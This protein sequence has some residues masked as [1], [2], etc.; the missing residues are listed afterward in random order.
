MKS[1]RERADAPPFAS[2]LPIRRTPAPP[3]EEPIASAYDTRV[4]QALRTHKRQSRMVSIA[5]IAIGLLVVA[6]SLLLGSRRREGRAASLAVGDDSTAVVRLLGEPP[7]RCQASNLAHLENQFPAGTPRPTVD[8]ELVRLR[9][10]TVAR[11]VYP[12]GQGCV[13]DDGA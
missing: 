1:G 11:W 8:E 2:E 4:D 6:V 10:G 9:R 12:K 7:H 5:I 13:P 3:Q